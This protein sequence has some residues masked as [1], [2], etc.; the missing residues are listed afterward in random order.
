MD[1]AD[2]EAG[3]GD[4]MV[5]TIMVGTMGDTMAGV[6]TGVITGVGAIT[7]VGIPHS[8]GDFR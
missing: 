7:P 5:G 4:T 2:T 1:T 8:I 3:E 6:F